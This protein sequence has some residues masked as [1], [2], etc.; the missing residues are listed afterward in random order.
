MAAALCWPTAVIKRVS[1]KRW[2]WAVKALRL[3]WPMKLPI[4]KVC[5]WTLKCGKSNHKLH[6][7]RLNRNF[8][9]TGVQLSSSPPI[10]NTPYLG[11]FL[12]YRER[13]TPK[14]LWVKK[15]F[16]ELFLAQRSLLGTEFRMRCRRNWVKS[17][18]CRR[19][20]NSPHLHHNTEIILLSVRSSRFFMRFLAV[21]KARIFN[22]KS[23]TVKYLFCELE[24]QS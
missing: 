21:W 16:S 10:K 3:P 24:P 2:T 8:F 23:F 14:G 4:F 6:P 9:R 20:N 18:F 1:F 12:L 7:E 15:Q 22:G 17:V 5:L 11:V 13:W 19:L